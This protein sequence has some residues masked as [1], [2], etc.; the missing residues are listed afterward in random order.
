MEIEE[1][2][3]RIKSEVGLTDDEIKVLFKTDEAIA[4]FYDEFRLS[5]GMKM[6]DDSDDSTED[7]DFDLSEEEKKEYDKTAAEDAKK[8]RKKEEL[9][10]EFDE[11]A[12]EELPE[13]KRMSF[14]DFVD[15]ILE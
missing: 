9:R 3:R 1:T 2:K 14:E 7:D 11:I 4:K 13:D 12:Q 8:S 10:K 6:L 5:A 15:G